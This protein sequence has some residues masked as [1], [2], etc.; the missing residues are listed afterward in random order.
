MCDHKDFCPLD[1]FTK[2]L[3]I[4]RLAKMVCPFWAGINVNESTHWSP[5]N[6]RET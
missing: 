3:S 4:G 2:L 6:L 5:G 1:V